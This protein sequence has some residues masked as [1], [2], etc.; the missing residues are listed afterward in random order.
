ML[1]DGPSAHRQP[2]QRPLD[3]DNAP[4]LPQQRR[5]FRPGDAAAAGGDDCAGA[6]PQLCQGLRLQRAEGSLAVAA[7]DLRDASARP[8]LQDGIR[9]VKGAAQS[10]GQGLAQGCLAA[11]GHADED[12]I[13]HL[14][15]QAAGDAFDLAV[16]NGTAS[17]E[18]CGPL[19]LGHQHPEPPIAGD[20]PALRLKQQCCAGRIINE[21]QDSLQPGEPG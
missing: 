12:D 20:A 5:I 16:S 8:L 10:V 15:R 13:L 7:E 18:L 4:I 19:C 17:E 9:I 11:A 2:V 3:P 1:G 6:F 14:P 21:V